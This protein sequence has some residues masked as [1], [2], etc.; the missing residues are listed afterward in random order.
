MSYPLFTGA[1]IE[2]TIMNYECIVTKLF[3]LC[4]LHRTHTSTYKAAYTDACKKH[5]TI[6]VCEA[7]FLKMNP[8]VRHVED[9]I[10]IKM[11]V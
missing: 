4:C 3:I 11:V 8:R 5:Y 1:E 6:A 9:I 7:V 2:G 10:K